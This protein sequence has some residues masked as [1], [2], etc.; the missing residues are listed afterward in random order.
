M[1]QTQKYIVGYIDLL[2]GKS[3]ITKDDNDK[4]L[5]TV[6]KNYC[7][8]KEMVDIH[9]SYASIPYTV[10]IFSDNIIIAIP[11]ESTILND[12]HPVIALNRMA[13]IV[14]AF[15]RVFLEQNILTRGS[16]TYGDLYID[17]LMVWGKALIDAY[18][19]ENTVANYPRVVISDKILTLANLW[20]E[21]QNELLQ[22]NNIT[23]DFDG[24]F[25]LNYLNY[26]QDNKIQ[27]LL[28]SSLKAT[29]EYLK[30]EQNG[31][32]IQKYK[33][34]RNYLLSLTDSTS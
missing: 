22:L 16:I 34:H 15:Q 7:I 8:V 28:S 10:K 12:N 1:L 11:S 27:Q 31:R 21:T 26:P 25:Y 3:L 6:Y 32:I 29:D 4:S 9:S 20:S 17:E 24:E 19:L 2:A 23:Q 30:T 5:N 14:G 13:A 18:E 33:W